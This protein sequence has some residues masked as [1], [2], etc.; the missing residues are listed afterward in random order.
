VL[1]STRHGILHMLCDGFAPSTGAADCLI[2]NTDSDA[3]S[4]EYLSTYQRRMPVGTL[5]GHT[6]VA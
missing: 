5:L 3:G 1:S 4:G 2:K 6:D